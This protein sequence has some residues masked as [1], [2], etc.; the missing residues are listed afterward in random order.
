MQTVRDNEAA[1]R[2]QAHAE[3]GA[4]LRRAG[5][6]LE[7]REPL[8]LAVDLAH[9]A[10]ATA[11]EEHALA[12]LRAAGARPRRRLISGPDALTRR[13]RRIA[14]LA[15]AGRPNREIAE[16]LVVTLGTVE[17]HLRNAYRKL[18]I[19]SRRQLA[20][21][22]GVRRRSAATSSTAPAHLGLRWRSWGA[23][24]AKAAASAW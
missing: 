13:E 9:R 5:R 20:D 2:A 15:A 12:E 16:V 7:A 24:K 10:G 19:E 18:G 8:R 22:L 4:A 11:L 14:E 21:A 1:E 23:Y 17:Y 6:R 3:L